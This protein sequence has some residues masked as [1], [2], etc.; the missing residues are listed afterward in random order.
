MAEDLIP[1]NEID[2]DDEEFVQAKCLCVHGECAQGDSECSKCY[3]GWTGRLCDIPNDLKT[4]T[5]GLNPGL[6]EDDE[7]EIFNPRKIRD[8]D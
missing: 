6:I 3:S 7:D 5:G 8:S 2:D 4:G 1:F